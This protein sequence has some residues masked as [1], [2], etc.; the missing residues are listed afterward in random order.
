MADY[1][2]IQVPTNLYLCL[3]RN[4]RELLVALIQL[5]SKYADKEGWFFRSNADMEAETNLKHGTTLN[6][7]LDALLNRGIIDFIPQQQGKG[8]KQSSRKYK[9]NFDTFKKYEDMKLAMERTHAWLDRCVAEHQRLK[10]DIVQAGGLAGGTPAARRRTPRT[11]GEAARSGPADLEQYLY[12]IV[13]GGTFNDLRAESARYCASKNPDGF[14]I[15]GVFTADG[16][17][18][19]LKT[20]NSILP[21]D[22][23]RHLLGM[24]QEPLDLFVG[25]E[26]GCDLIQFV[27][28]ARYE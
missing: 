10:E 6:G 5:S 21:E 13:Q 8:V 12:A 19:M 1:N 15:G 14:G 22:K 17:S 16:M 23:P 24:G 11:V 18:E 4:C 3:D 25:A 7:A 9:V 28:L 20:V 27:H 2:F 26:Y